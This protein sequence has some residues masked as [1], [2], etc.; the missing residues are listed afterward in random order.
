MRKRCVYL[1]AFLFGFSLFA[2]VADAAKPVIQIKG[3]D[4]TLSGKTGV[5][6]A[7]MGKSKIEGDIQLLIGPNG[8][9]LEEGEFEFIDGE[10]GSFT[11]T[12]ALGKRGYEF[13]PDSDE[14]ED[15]LGDLLVALAAAEE[16]QATVTSLDLRVV[17]MS[18]KPKPTKTG[19]AITWSVNIKASI[20]GNADGEPY[21]TNVS[22]IMKHT[23]EIVIPLAGSTWQID[24]TSQVAI[25]SMAKQKDEG[26]FTMSLGPQ[27]GLADGEFEA[28]GDVGENFS[29]T[30]STDA[31]G[32]LLFQLN[33]ADV[34][35]VL[36]GMILAMAQVDPQ[37]GI[38]GVATDIITK[39]TK[40]KFKF[41]PGI[42]MSMS[43]KI[44][45]NIIFTILGGPVESSG[46][47]SVKG[48]GVPQS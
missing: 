31:K 19:I 22:I 18:V 39:K 12:F 46:T 33:E 37:S 23:G 10:G 40:L 35:A 21:Q 48:N 9:D 41:Q 6:V 7:K 47:L 32:K 2:N 28:L 34:E 20:A 36:N 30:Y 17:K 26:I 27:G 42:S 29:G 13:T 24:S 3:I 14:L 45:Y 15:Y 5:T 43:I 38:T 44:S 8:G 1:L 16:V 25:K 4:W 11:G